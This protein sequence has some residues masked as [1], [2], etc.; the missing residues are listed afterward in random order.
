[1]PRHATDRTRHGLLRAGL[2]LTA[3]TAAFGGAATAA[4]HAAHSPEAG[5][6]GGALRQ[7]T[8]A[9]PQAALG[10]A[11]HHSVTPL[12]S[13]QLYPLAKTG[14]DPLTNGVGAQ[15]ADFRPVRTTA[16]TGVLSDGQALQDLPVVGQVTS[17]LPR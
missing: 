8:E 12:K 7:L 1:M 17:A 3:A 4:A 5:Q 6:A 11:L 9:D 14:T 13:L 2:T 10:S 15:V 16:V